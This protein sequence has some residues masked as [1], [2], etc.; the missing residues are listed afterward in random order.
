MMHV[1]AVHYVTGGADGIEGWPCS[2]K[3]KGHAS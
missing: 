3:V 2:G 1:T